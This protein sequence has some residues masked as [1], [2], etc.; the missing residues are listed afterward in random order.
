MARLGSSQPVELARSMQDLIDG[1]DLSSFGAAPTKF[2]PD[3]LFPLTRAHNQSLPY[4]AMA[5]QIRALGVPDD[6]ADRFWAV[7]KDNITVK[8]DLAP[9]WALFS[10]GAEPLVD[11]ED[12]DFVTQAMA[13]LPPR[14]WTAET[15]GQW[16]AAVRDATGR[17]GKGLFRPLRRAL[18]GRDAGPEMADL[19]PLL[20]KPRA[21][22]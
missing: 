7:A 20:Q 13:L 22:G 14:P 5:G 17:R 1:F 19:M 8:A 4:A 21:A 12:A 11:P 6:L 9:W 16:T 10:D 18:T 3:D 2:D 15:W